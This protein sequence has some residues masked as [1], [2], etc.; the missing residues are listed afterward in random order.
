MSVTLPVMPRMLCL[1]S[2]LR[3]KEKSNNECAK[4]DTVY[5]LPCL[6]CLLIIS[7]ACCVWS[8]FKARAAMVACILCL[9]CLVR[10]SHCIIKPQA[11]GAKSVQGSAAQLAAERAAEQKQHAE[12]TAQLEAQIQALDSLRYD[13]EQA[14]ANLTAKLEMS[15]ATNTGLEIQI[16]EVSP[17]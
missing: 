16:L 4:R 1:G 12:Q 15:S 2:F 14:K 3:V 7:I 9:L 5:G 10:F 6:L 8:P 11:E 13:L 17:A